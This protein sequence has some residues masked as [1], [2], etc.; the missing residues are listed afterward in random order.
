MLII[1]IQ[2]S[3][4]HTISN[5]RRPFTSCV[6]TSIL[7]HFYRCEIPASQRHHLILIIIHYR[8]C[9][10]H[11]DVTARRCSTSCFAFGCD[12]HF[13]IFASIQLVFMRLGKC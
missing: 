7:N 13:S 5:E 3:T 2:R 1:H 12:A 9:Y 10:T 6:A 8:F 4:T 11:T